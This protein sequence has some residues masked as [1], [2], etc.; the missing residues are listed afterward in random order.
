MI[1]RYQNIPIIKNS[2]GTRYYRDNKYP[3]IPLTINDIYVITTIG[4]R[5]DLL[6]LQY[7]NDPSLWWVISSANENLPQNS[8]Y[9]PVGTQLRI[10]TDVSEI[11]TNYRSLNQ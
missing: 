1:N 11:L 8:L 2:E 10:P 9:I 4:D 3:R 6:A 5:F 7:Y